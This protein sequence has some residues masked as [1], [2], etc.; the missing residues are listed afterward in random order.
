H[1]TRTIPFIFLTGRGTRENVRHGMHLGADDYLT[2]PFTKPEL[3]QS[4]NSQL[5]KRAT[6]KSHYE[7]YVRKLEQKPEENNQYDTVTGIGNFLYLQQQFDFF[8]NKLDNRQIRNLGTNFYL[9]LCL[10]KIELKKIKQILNYDTYN[11]LLVK[12]RQRL[13]N[14]LKQTVQLALIGDG[15]FAVL[16]PPIKDRQDISAIADLILKQFEKSFILNKKEFF[17]DARIGISFYPRSG[18][19]LD[20]LVKSSRTILDNTAQFATQKYQFC[21]GHSNFDHDKQVFLETELHYAIERDQLEVFYQPQISLSSSAVTGLEALLRWQHPELG[22]VSPA[23]F[24][25]IAE[26]T[27]LI[28]AIGYWTLQ[29]ATEQVRKW[30]DLYDKS[31][32]LAINMSAHQLSNADICHELLR[33]LAEEDFNPELLDLEIT[34]SILIEDFQKASEKLKMLQRVG[35]KI[36]ID[37]FGTGYSSFNYTRLFPWDILKIDRCFVNNI[38]KSKINAAITKG[39]IEM[40]HALGFKVIAEGVETSSELAILNEYNCDEV[41]GYFLGRPVSAATLERNIFQSFE[42]IKI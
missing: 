20:E 14:N 41:Q 1:S 22:L 28:E 10:V 37:D 29:T 33:I 15:E 40:S 25:P 12:L 42:T 19:N 6:I 3:L 21:S 2:K 35:I 24:I 11:E 9:P 36:A 31:L 16:C 38:H 7:Q 30:Q 34:E 13:K 32:R 4:I 27:G 5:K 26:E 8:I 39:L 17:V 18:H 23:D